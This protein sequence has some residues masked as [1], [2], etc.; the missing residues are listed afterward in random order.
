MS[1]LKDFLG[2][3]GDS[4]FPRSFT[5]DICG[6]ETFG[7]NLCPDCAETVIFNDGATCPVCGR[8]TARPEICLECKDSAPLYKRAFSAIVYDGGGKILMSKFKSGNGY[9]KE[10]FADRLAEKLKDFH[11]ADCIIAVP[12]TEKSVRDRGYNQSALLAESLSE[13]IKIPV[14]ENAAVKIK[15]TAQQKQ[16]TKKERAENLESCFKIP[17]RT[18]VKG[19]NILI[20][21]DVMTTGATAEALT[22]KL[23]GAGAKNVYVAT[24]MSVEFRQFKNK[25]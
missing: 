19:K 15:P 18:L 25:K 6:R 16:L 3:V 24:V 14:I 17:D 21:D 22:K 7:A 8:K 11:E 5:C 20:V 13:R 10:F 9:L 12:M 2:A 1:K 4:L 23:L